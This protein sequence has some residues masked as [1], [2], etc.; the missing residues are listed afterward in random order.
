MGTAAAHSREP[1]KELAGN[2]TQQNVQNPSRSVSKSG[3]PGVHTASVRA[4]VES[5]DSSDAHWTAKDRNRMVRALHAAQEKYHN[6]EAECAGLSS[7]LEALQVRILKPQSS[8]HSLI[9]TPQAKCFWASMLPL[10]KSK[11]LFRRP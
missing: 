2:S 10:M 11:S 3:R 1:F 6:S 9:M 7:Q 8:R 5:D 4:S